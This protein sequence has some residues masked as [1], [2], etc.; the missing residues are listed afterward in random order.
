MDT[1]RIAQL[2]WANYAATLASARVTPGLEVALRDDVI[3]TSSAMFPTPDAN[4]ACL[5]RTTEQGIEGLIAEV[6]GHFTAVD[7]PATIFVSPA[8]TPVDLPQRLR[9]HGFVR[10]PERE[11]WM[12]LEDLAR[13]KTPSPTPRIAV[14]QIGADQAL[15][16]AR[17]FMAAFG[18]PVEMA[19]QMAQLLQPSMCLPDVHH[20]MAF[21]DDEP[22]GVSSLLCYEHFGILG[23]AGV[24]PDR[25]GSRAATNM[26]IQAITDAQAHHV[27]TLMLQTSAGTRLERFLRINGFRTAFIRDCYTQI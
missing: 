3:L 4:H 13:L 18:M 17:I 24:L 7:M 15:A 20:Y 9:H 21:W 12:V 11:A 16:F 8:C 26:T 23:S 5:L 27:D 10:Q 1:T 19:E 14:R 2:E 6:E 25:R 22:V